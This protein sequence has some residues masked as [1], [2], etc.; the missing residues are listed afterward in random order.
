MEQQYAE[1]IHAAVPHAAAEVSAL[2]HFVDIH[3]DGRRQSRRIS[4]DSSGGIV[5]EGW[6]RQ[7]ISSIIH[8]PGAPG[9]EDVLSLLQRGVPML[10]VNRRSHCY[11]VV[12]ARIHLL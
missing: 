10:A 7:G 6:R 3:P 11:R 5:L 4:Y 2:T 12:F 9:R 8:K 1:A